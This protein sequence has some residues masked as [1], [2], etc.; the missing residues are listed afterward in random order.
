MRIRNAIEAKLT[1]AL[2]PDFLEITDNSNKH[3]GHSG[4]HPDGESHFA[5]VVVSTA[6]EGLT[7][8]KRQRLVY[9]A[10]AEEM[11]NHIHAL[12]LKTQTPS[13]YKT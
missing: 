8:V 9:A 4:A 7:R 3:A 12:E 6:F 1:E 11:D 2:S 13:E 10:L 5:L